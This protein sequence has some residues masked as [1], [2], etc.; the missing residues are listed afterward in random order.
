MYLITNPLEE[1]KQHS[2]YGTS[3]VTLID[4]AKTEGPALVCAQDFLTEAIVA[5]QEDK[6]VAGIQMIRCADWMIQHHGENLLMAGLK[7]F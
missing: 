6:L 5:L 7:E 2:M 3:V 1:A 4:L